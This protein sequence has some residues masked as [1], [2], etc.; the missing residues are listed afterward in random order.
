MLAGYF[1][2]F[3]DVP[4][5]PAVPHSSFFKGKELSI[6]ARIKTWRRE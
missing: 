5:Q 1:L 6:A 3:D 4:F 2:E